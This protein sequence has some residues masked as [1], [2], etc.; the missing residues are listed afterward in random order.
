MIKTL[1]SRALAVIAVCALSLSAHAAEVNVAVASNF[2]A[3]MKVIAQHFEKETGHRAKLSFG[4]TGQFYAQI[5]NGAPFGILLAA[6]ATTPAKIAQEGL[7]LRDSTF[8]YASGTLVLWSKK[9]T[10][11]DQ[12]GEVLKQGQFNKIAIA[13]PKLAPYG[14]AALQ[15]ITKMD[16]GESLKSKIVEGSNI[17]Q[18]FQFVSSENASLGFVALS[19]VYENNKLKEGSAWIIPK[20]MYTPIKQDAIMLTGSENNPAAQALMKYLR[21]E[22]AKVIIRSFGYNL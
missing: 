21:S 16:L 9:P 1:T 6:D 4:A 14:A 22:Q 19:Q 3:P 13:N 8:T 12:S 11:I 2:T 7:G 17:S 20:D 15:V 18:T 5:K 10:L